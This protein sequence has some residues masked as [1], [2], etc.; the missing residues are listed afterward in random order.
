MEEDGKC[1]GDQLG[2]NRLA[3]EAISLMLYCWQLAAKY[4]MLLATH[5]SGVDSMIAHPRSKKRPLRPQDT[6]KGDQAPDAKRPAKRSS[7]D[8]VKKT[9][10]PVK[11]PKT[12]PQKQGK[13][14]TKT[15]KKKSGDGDQKKRSADQHNF[16]E[17]L[18]QL[19]NDN[20]DP[21]HVSWIDSEEAVSFK[22][23]GF[24]E[25]V[26]DKFFQGLKYDSFVR[27]LNRW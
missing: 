14:T 25:H 9:S 16:P 19:I 15:S 1:L 11:G 13:S 24:Q 26:L 7:Q 5:R 18:M 12:V 20:V 23:D 21:D 27:K 8:D 10:I 3:A 17:K 6:T 2:A 4:L 22:T